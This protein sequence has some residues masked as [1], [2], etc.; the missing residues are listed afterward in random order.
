M[1]KPQGVLAAD[2]DGRGPRGQAP[3]WRDKTMKSRTILAAAVALLGTPLVAIAQQA[4]PPPAGAPAAAAPAQPQV[5]AQNIRGTIT[6]FDAAAK[7]L[8]VK[9]REGQNVELAVPD[10]VNVAVHKAF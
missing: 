2:P 7:V 5:P 3:N 4:A 6:A 8:K 1:R 9:T 10:T